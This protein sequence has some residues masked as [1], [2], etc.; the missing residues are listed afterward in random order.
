[1]N[2]HGTGHAHPGR[3]GRNIDPGLGRLE[4]EGALERVQDIASAF[5]GRGGPLAETPAES[6]A[7]GAATG[8]PTYY[9]QPLLQEPV[10]KWYIPAYFHLGGLSGAAIAL[11]AVAEMGGGRSFRRLAQG[12]RLVSV[13][14]E[15]LGTGLLIA[16][17]GRPG[18][19]LHMMRVFRPT[20]P[21]SVG[22]WVLLGSGALGTGA[23]LLS[24][25]PGVLGRLGSVATAGAGLLGLVLSGYTGVLL[26]NTAVPLWQEAQR[27][28]PPLF[29]AA[30]A[31]SV[32]TLLEFLPLGRHE[33][34]VVRRFAAAGQAATLVSMVALEREAGQVPRVTRP[35]RQGLPGVLWRG[36]GILTAAGLGLGLLSRRH[37]LAAL[38]GTAGA[39]ALRFAVFHAGKHSARDPRASFAVQRARTAPGATTTPA[40]GSGS[41]RRG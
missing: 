34:R 1:M 5:P 29:L 17:L 20:S 15:I 37:R 16:D 30:S 32:G 35:L 13:T 2:P 33:R 19:F 21:M 28:L 3:D 26:A 18:R 25:R 27:S 11:G 36:A 7:R 31:A 22:S 9:D 10:W 40:A 8:L 14:G 6:L 12:C 39:I 24:G 23:L 41:A 4:G 38:I